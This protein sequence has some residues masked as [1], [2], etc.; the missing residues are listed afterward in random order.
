[1]PLKVFAMRWQFGTFEVIM[2]FEGLVKYFLYG[3]RADSR[4]FIIPMEV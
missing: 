4:R 2:I 3:I 1:M